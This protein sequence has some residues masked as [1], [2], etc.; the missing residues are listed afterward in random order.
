MVGLDDFG[1]GAQGGDFEDTEDF[2]VYYRSDLEPG[3]TFKGE[4]FM[5]ELKKSEAE[6][7]HGKPFFN[8]VITNHEQEEK[9]V[10][11]YWSPN[12][13][14][15]AKGNYYGKKGGAHYMLI[16][17]I[18]A[19]LFGTDR[20]EAKYHSVIFEKFREGINNKI[21]SVEAEM[22]EPS[23]RGVHPVLSITSAETIGE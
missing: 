8:I 15:M 1:A 3:D 13:D 12:E 22:V 18:L 19:C 14:A 20:N 11:T 6:A 21:V 23:G 2:E 10:V 17:G 4:I 5:S 16:D 9:W 7:T